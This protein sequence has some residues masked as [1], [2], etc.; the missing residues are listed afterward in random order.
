MR[1]KLNAWV[2]E[3]PKMLEYTP[4]YFQVREIALCLALGNDAASIEELKKRGHPIDMIM[5]VHDGLMI[6]EA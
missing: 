4:L 3:N 2:R 6:A 5:A 1:G